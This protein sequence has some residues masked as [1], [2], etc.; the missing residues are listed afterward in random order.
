M[1]S[2]PEHRFK[3]KLLISCPLASTQK[4]HVGGH[5]GHELNV[6]FKWEVDDLDHS[7]CHVIHIHAG[8]DSG[9]TVRLQN[10]FSHAIR[11]FCGGIA[12]IDLGAGNSI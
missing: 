5:D 3:S 4:R 6:G 7:I 11:H 9:R 1:K 10:T 2:E 12:N 8:L